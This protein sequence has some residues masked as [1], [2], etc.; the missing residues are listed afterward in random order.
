MNTTGIFVSETFPDGE[1]IL[2]EMGL[3]SVAL[4]SITPRWKRMSY[5]AVMMFI[6]KEKPQ[7]SALSLEK[8]K[9]YL[10]AIYHLCE[11]QD[12]KA[13]KYMLDLPITMTYNSIS[14]SLPF[15]EYLL[16]RGLEQQLLNVCEDTINS[17][18]N[19]ES[20]LASIYLLK[21]R[22]LA[23]IVD[24][25]MACDIFKEIC[26]VIDKYSE[27]YI[28]ATARLAM[29]QI[30]SGDYKEGEKNLISQLKELEKA[31][32]FSPKTIELK[33]EIF[34]YL[35]WYA[36]NASKFKKAIYYYEIAVKI[37]KE[38]G[39]IHKIV[40]PLLHLGV[41][42]KKLKNYK[43]AITYLQQAKETATI[44]MNESYIEWVDH[45]LAYVFLEQGNYCLAEQLCKSC[46][47]KAKERH[48]EENN[49]GKSA[50][51]DYYEQLG[52]IKLAKG[53]VNEAIQLLEMSLT[54]RINIANKHGTASSLKHLSIALWYQKKYLKSLYFLG[55]SLKTYSELKILNFQ[56]FFNTIKLFLEWTNR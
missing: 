39:L 30:Y 52:L 38:S 16:F 44:F 37:R 1:F 12:W 31:P 53:K 6:T 5:M 46:I 13:T 24:R 2:R 3:E 7:L 11:L 21:A 19:T 40:D 51:P 22:S 9:G 27:D 28:E 18:P 20:Q 10:H 43:N 34:Q 35:A 17:F 26:T 29:G 55:N 48:R 8:V 42:Q 33:A 25:K 49:S 23:E 15:S 41:I 45:H 14:L 36:M 47:E 32:N 56:R 50:I 54:C 4:N